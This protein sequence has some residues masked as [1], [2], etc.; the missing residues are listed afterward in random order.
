MSPISGRHSIEIIDE[1]TTQSGHSDHN[2]QLQ[3]CMYINVIFYQN[4][5]TFF[6]KIWSMKTD[7]DNKK[8]PNNVFLNHLITR[9]PI[10]SWAKLGMGLAIIL[11]VRQ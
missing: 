1:N 6:H 8:R 3:V 10:K 5:S 7:D 9:E 2:S 4:L 11:N